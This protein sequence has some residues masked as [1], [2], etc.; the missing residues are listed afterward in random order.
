MDYIQLNLN[1]APKN[2]WLEI[3]TQELADI[4]FDSFMEEGQTLQAFIPSDLFDKK[5]V[6]ELIEEYRA[7]DIAIEV[8]QIHIPSQNWNAT[9]EADY[10]PVK[11]EDKLIIRAPFHSKEGNYKMSIEIQPQMSFGT[12]HHQTTY[13]LCDTLL[14]EDF[15]QK[16]VLDVGTGTGVL[17]ILAAKLN[18]SHIVGTDIEAGAVEN[19]IENIGRNNISNFEILEGD[20]EVVTKKD[21]DVIIANIN[22]NVLMQHLKSYSERIKE[23]GSLFLSGFFETDADSLIEEAKKFGFKFVQLYTRETWAVLKFKK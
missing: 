21:F 8:E 22:K 9:W 7:K 10:Q 19:A 20:I 3:I 15:N 11:I 17:G 13:L 12:G 14:D 1:I 4:D 5:K 23:G 16:S 2:P 18:A 6:N